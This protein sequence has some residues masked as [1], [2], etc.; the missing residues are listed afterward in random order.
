M[1]RSGTSALAR[2]L[3]LMGIYFGGENAGMGRNPENEKGF[4]ERRDVRLLNDTI[5]F[6]ANCDWDRISGLDLDAL[7]AKDGFAEAAAD[8][9]LNL[10]A[11]RPWFM[12]EPRLCILFPIWR[13]A[14]E[15][16]ICIH[17]TRNP[18]EV[19]HS[20]KAR[21]RI[22][23]R[24]GLALWEFYNI[25][26]L[27][28]SAG[29][30]RILVAYE[31]LLGAPLA[32][33]ERLHKALAENGVQGLRIPTEK[34]L[35]GFLDPELR[36]Q[37]RSLQA[38]RAT[39]T[40]SQ[41]ALYDLLANRS[42]SNPVKAPRLSRKCLETLRNYERHVDVASRIAQA[43]AR[44]SDRSAQNLELQ[45]ALKRLELTHALESARDLA[46]RTKALEV[47]HARRQSTETDLKVQLAVANQ[48]DK[49]L[50]RELNVLERQ[51]NDLR[52]RNTE[53]GIQFNDTRKENDKLQ[54]D[55]NDLRQRHADVSGQ[56]Q[57]LRQQNAELDGEH[58]KLNRLYDD[59]TAQHQTLRQQ[60]A[61]LDG[62][63]TKLNRLYDDLTAQH[64]TLR[65]QNAEL[66]GEHTKLNRLY[67]DLTAQHQTLRQQNAE[68]DGEHT[69][70]NRLYDDL[71]AQHQTLRQ[72]N[73][74]LDGEHTKLNR[75]YDD[76]TA[77][78]Q[79]LRQQNAEL[80]GEHTKLNRLYDDLTAQHQ[81]L[82]S[83]TAQLQSEIAEALRS[84]SEQRASALTVVK[85]WDSRL[86]EH[87]ARSATLSRLERQLTQNI[88]TL[89]NS[90]RYR[91]ADAV[92]TLA[93]RA[94]FRRVHNT[95]Q[96]RMANVTSSHHAT[97]HA[98]RDLA[99]RLAN[100]IG[101][102][103]R[104]M[105]SQ[106][107]ALQ[108]LGSFSPHRDEQV[109]ISLLQR[110]LQTGHRERE[111]EHLDEHVERLV[112]IGE[113]LLKSRRWRLG[114]RLASMPRRLL[115][116]Q[117]LPTA[118]EA[119]SRNMQSYRFDKRSTQQTESTTEIIPPEAETLQKSLSSNAADTQEDHQTNAPAPL[120]EISGHPE[121]GGCETRQET[122]AAPARDTPVDIV[123]CVHNALDD[124]QRCLHSIIAKTT[125]EFRLIV[126]ND[127]SNSETTRWLRRFAS[128]GSMVDLIETNGPLGYTRAAN[129]GL[130][131]STAEYVVLLNSDTIVGRLWLEGLIECIGSDAKIGIVGPL[132]N[133][134]SW[135]SIPE[136]FDKD[137]GWAVNALPSGY[138]VDEFNELVQL[139]SLRQFPRV[140]F[141]NGFCLMIGRQVI[142][143]IGYL[144][145]ESFPQGY[146]EE[147]DYCLRARDAGLELALADH[148]Y[149]YHAKSKSFGSATRDR[150]AAQGREMLQGKHGRERIE[151][152]TE[153][154]RNSTALA[155][156]RQAVAEGLATTDAAV[157]SAPVAP[158]A[159]PPANAV[160]SDKILFVLPVKGGSGGANSVIQEVAGMRTLGIE[161]KAI[162]H[163]R[164]RDRFRHFYREFFDSSDYFLFF[165]TDEDLMAMAEPFDTIVATLWSTPAQIA[166]IARRWPS[167]TFIYYVQDYE[168]W[169]FPNDP[170]LQ[171]EAAESY[172]L[173]PDMALMAKTDWIC[174]TVRERHGREVYRVAPSLDHAVFYT[175]PKNPQSH[176]GVVTVAAMIRPSTPRRAPL[177]T[178]RV[179]REL[180]T[181]ARGNVRAV[182]FGCES[183][184]LRT[185]IARNEP[186]L[187]LDFAFDNRGLLTRSQ[188]A[189][190]LREA[191]IFLDLSDYQAFGRTG[192]EAMACGCATVLTAH[193]GVYEYA[194][195]GENA[196]LVDVTSFDETVAAVE[197]LVND[198][199]I[200]HRM[201][202]SAAETAAKYS[203][204]RASLSEL[205]VF[206]LVSVLKRRRGFGG[207]AAAS[208]RRGIEP[209]TMQPK[210][211]SISVL[212]PSRAAGNERPLSTMESRILRP[213]RHAS[214]RDRLLVREAT[215]LKSLAEQQPDICI[216]PSAGLER[217]PGARKIVEL[218]RERSIKLVLETDERPDA[219]SPA[220]AAIR[221][222]AKAADRIIVSTNSLHEAYD[223]LNAGVT[224]LPA[225]IDEVLWIESSVGEEPLLQTRRSPDTMRLVAISDGSGLPLLAEGWREIMEAVGKTVFVAGIR[226]LQWRPWH[227]LG[228]CA[229]SGPQP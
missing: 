153:R 165:S 20:L 94:L 144:D 31:E 163:E 127:G 79:T 54:R 185:H 224:V 108:A 99:A 36:T 50:K 23:I 214:L 19:A 145:E 162:T 188:V 59:L 125:V 72:Q 135:Q 166:P 208:Y 29:L 205:S 133:A 11:H 17:I 24:T 95:I 30:P 87:K 132:S 101:A 190:L 217:V 192:L 93:S 3:N 77:Q 123:V 137:G 117:P 228:S 112:A 49:T 140:D 14:L 147:N 130:R 37:R 6:N 146:G 52:Q 216:V 114:Q 143:R 48:Q 34:E 210:A 35:L 159:N 80:D 195:H 85:Q 220:Q 134:A 16:P 40:A 209:V 160:N 51:R 74:E 106:S 180:A 121:A 118:V 126:I 10:D 222:I 1:H 183:A 170:D 215:S 124:V 167:K 176:D 221:H 15:C 129:R 39:A 89:L 225:A 33:V 69:K 173:L 8:V 203:I 60:N 84:L 191:D 58:T 156:I 204:L 107:E 172:T 7:D 196:V 96:S 82:Q 131:A 229:E 109:T 5:L 168:P 157:N 100:S 4:W 184:D 211:V 187:R 12:K 175:D 9:V 102:V 97:R 150:L 179:L 154:L 53:T 174:R 46:A 207:S 226:R 164:Y 218:C 119:L 194:V 219:R 56:N 73:A 103:A 71:T 181:R 21:N 76:L 155:D 148:C 62:E 44:Q 28:A 213:L 199:G 149:V 120:P 177:R 47:E 68:L 104:H 92:L 152:G 227:G 206:R 139:K 189:E 111:L 161:A 128:E 198:A 136:R 223:G 55:C 115:L 151:R 32:T 197:R 2:L 169:F 41:L 66:D 122:I 142:D 61:E 182:V 138:N 64:Q 171:A 200:R 81:E 83:R 201:Q 212:T 105:P 45:L 57:E 67:D 178:L 13:K 78:H 88:E 193:G 43:N 116:R 141:V 158:A 42:T 26:A 186:D 86:A 75:L 90:R 65:Q 91:L 27:T 202:F 38:F 22:P 18:L 70:L 110:N 98:S 63:H 113:A 25:R